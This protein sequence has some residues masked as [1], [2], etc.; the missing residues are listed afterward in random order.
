MCDTY[1][2]KKEKMC[3]TWGHCP[4]YEDSRKKRMPPTVTLGEEAAARWSHPTE[5]NVLRNQ[6]KRA[7]TEHPVR[8]SLTLWKRKTKRKHL[9]ELFVNGEFTANREEG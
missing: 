5:R 1:I 4:V 3:S 2:N 9:K 6:A 8:C 7:R